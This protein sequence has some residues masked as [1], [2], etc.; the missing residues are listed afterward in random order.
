MDWEREGI[1]IGDEQ[2]TMQ[3]ITQK[4][5]KFTRKIFGFILE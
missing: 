1:N 5:L 4:L 3:Q 2:M